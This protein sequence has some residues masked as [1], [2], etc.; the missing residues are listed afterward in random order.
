MKVDQPEQ[1][2]FPDPAVDRVM[3]V[4]FNLAAEVQVLRERNRVL[5]HLLVAK[6]V[7][8]PDAVERFRGSDAEEQA[9]AADRRD[10]VRHLLEPV[11]GRAASRNDVESARGR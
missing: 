5:E 10:Y 1:T 8:E 3:G 7:L 6:G 9:I 4:L 2:F 11:L